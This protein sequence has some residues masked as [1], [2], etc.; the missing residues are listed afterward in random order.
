VRRN[1]ALG[2]RD[3]AADERRLV[4]RRRKLTPSE[5]K[6][7]FYA[8]AAQEML[9]YQEQVAE[10]T[11][12]QRQEHD[13]L[14]QREADQWR[15]V[16]WTRWLRLGS[17]TIKQAA[18]V[19]E[20]RDPDSPFHGSDRYSGAAGHSRQFARKLLTLADEYLKPVSRVH[21]VR[22]PRYR[23][24]EIVA[25]A[26]KHD[27]AHARELEKLA[28]LLPRESAVKGRVSV[29][30]MR[31]ELVVEFARELLDQGIGEIRDRDIYLPMKSAE[32]F[33]RLVKAKGATARR[34]VEHKSAQVLERARLDRTQFPDLPKVV[35]AA[36]KPRSTSART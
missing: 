19:L 36:G 5:R 4:K 26:S 31:A 32:F 28:K 22:A 20:G 21:G 6:T 8:E 14:L 3:P 23:T 24:T 30:R 33:A 10:L 17:W 11:E 15:I 9:R 35:L 16:L 1:E 18:Y 7:R 34:L 27:L 25:L 29:E 13:R 12:E 2:H